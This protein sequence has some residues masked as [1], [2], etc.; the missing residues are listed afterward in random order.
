MKLPHPGAPHIDNLI[1]TMLL[2]GNGSRHLDLDRIARFQKFDPALFRARFL[3]LETDFT[4]RPRN[5]YEEFGK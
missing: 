4:L 3:E 5:S 2:A 1:A